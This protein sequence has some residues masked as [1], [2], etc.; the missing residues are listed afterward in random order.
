MGACCSKTHK[1][2][3]GAI[4]NYDEEKEPLGTQRVL[5]DGSLNPFVKADQ[6]ESGSKPTS[7]YSSPTK[8]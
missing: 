1:P 7:S 3:N 2:I 8:V 6:Y 5:D 4:I